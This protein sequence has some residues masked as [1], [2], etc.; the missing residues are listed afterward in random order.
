M[1]L[2]W[3]LEG[4]TRKLWWKIAAFYGPSVDWGYLP[5]LSIYCDKKD[6]DCGWWWHKPPVVCG[7]NVANCDSLQDIVETMIEEYQHHLQDPERTDEEEYEAE[8]KAVAKRDAWMFLG[9]VV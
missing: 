7:V 1:R 5:Y 8:A 9:E 2:T 6:D 3:K 4:L